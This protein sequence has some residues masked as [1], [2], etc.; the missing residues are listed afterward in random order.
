[1]VIYQIT[2]HL[3]KDNEEVNAHVK[4]LWAMLDAE[5]V[6]DPL[7]EQED[8]NRGHEGNHRQSPHGDSAISITPPEEHGREHGRDNRDL[9]DIIRYRD[10]RGRIKNRHRER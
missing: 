9:H 6:V 5:T 2:S 10:A 4:F 3:H 1:M 8:K 7:H